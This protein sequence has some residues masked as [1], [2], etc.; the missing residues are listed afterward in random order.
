MWK[1]GTDMGPAMMA[2]KKAEG[3]SPASDRKTIAVT[4][5]GSPEWKEWIEG[6]AEHCRLDVAK[7]IDLAVV[8]FAKSEGYERKA[9]QR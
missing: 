1:Q 5:K 9:P 6:L 7:V 2:K 4:I 8:D 3:S